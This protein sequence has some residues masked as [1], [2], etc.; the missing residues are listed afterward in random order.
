MCVCA[1]CAA[2]QMNESVVLSNLPCPLKLDGKWG[3]GHEKW[4]KVQI[5][6]LV[7]GILR[8]LMD[9]RTHIWVRTRPY[10]ASGNHDGCNRKRLERELDALAPAVPSPSSI[11]QPIGCDSFTSREYYLSAV[12]ALQVC[13]YACAFVLLMCVLLYSRQGSWMALRTEG[14]DSDLSSFPFPLSFPLS[15]PHIFPQ[16]WVIISL[17]E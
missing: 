11:E 13:L 5:V 12:R 7:F 8:T 16:T 6:V 15:L 3:G 14:P 1:H 9:M 17:L 2:F 10:S 4:Q